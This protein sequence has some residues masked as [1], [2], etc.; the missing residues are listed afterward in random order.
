MKRRSLRI[1]VPSF[2]LF[3]LSGLLGAQAADVPVVL[4][5]TDP[6]AFSASER[7]ELLAAAEDVERILQQGYPIPFTRLV[8]KGWLDRD[9]VVFAAG[10]LQ[11]A[12]YEVVVVEGE[13]GSG[14]SRLWILVGIPLG[15]RTGWIPVE[16]SPLSETSCLFR[17]VPWVGD[18]GGE[19]DASY[20]VFDRVVELVPNSAP[21]AQ[22]AVIGMVVVD[23]QNTMH[24]RV[25]DRSGAIIAYVWSV[26]G[27]EVEVSTNFVFRHTFTEIG[28]HEVTLV[29]FDDRGAQA[30]ATELVDVLAEGACGCTPP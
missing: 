13:D 17:R 20:L 12:G 9:F 19:F 30:T 23:E 1:L 4:Q 26:D 5:P 27:E 2:L 22:I 7:A 18:A 8:S 21:T 25:Q 3:F 10:I 28:E 11:F 15:E 14:G 29:A 16:A 24:A 6:A